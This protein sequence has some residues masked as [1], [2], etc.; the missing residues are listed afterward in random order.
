MDKRG[1]SNFGK[2]CMY[3]NS[4]DDKENSENRL[5]LMAWS[6]GVTTDNYQRYGQPSDQP[7]EQERFF[8]ISTSL[9]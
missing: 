6:A 4:V 3:Q 9:F 5:D 7:E 1:W 2:L 8:I